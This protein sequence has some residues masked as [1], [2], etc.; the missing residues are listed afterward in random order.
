[1]TQQIR[2]VTL[3]DDAEVVRL[4]HL[5][6][7]RLVRK[8]HGSTTQCRST[9][10]PWSMASTT[11]RSSTPSMTGS[12][13]ILAGEA[14]IEFDGVRHLLAP[15]MAVF[16]PR[17]S[18][19]GYRVTKGPNEMAGGLLAGTFLAASAQARGRSMVDKEKIFSIISEHVNAKRV[20][21][22]RRA[23]AWTSFE[24]RREGCYVWDVDGRRYIDCY[25]SAG[26]FNVGR[27]N[28]VIRQ[29]VSTPSP[30]RYRP[31]PAPEARFARRP[32]ERN[33][34]WRPELRDV[35]RRRRRG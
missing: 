18:R 11:A 24:H 22:W 4:D 34:A 31:L 14:E 13:Y 6:S 17:G 20:A 7:R 3:K 12:F 15:G 29:A 16:V 8:A 19:Y 5:T 10:R 21:G 28:P 30:R 32:P 25:N 9:S 23:S 1:M 26:V 2:I 27:A 33:Y 35:Q